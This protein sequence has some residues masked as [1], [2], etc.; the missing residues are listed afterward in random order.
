MKRINTLWCHNSVFLHHRLVD[1]VKSVNQEWIL[2]EKIIL[3]H[4]K[5]LRT[6]SIIVAKSFK[7]LH[8]EVDNCMRV[9]WEWSVAL[10]QGRVITEKVNTS[11]GHQESAINSR[12]CFD[13]SGSASNRFWITYTSFLSSGENVALKPRLGK[14]VE[15]KLISCLFFADFNF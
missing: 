9:F 15:R 3:K 11:S 14:S 2:E 4:K 5:T 1:S 13:N 6:D 12:K 10:G 8:K 7:L